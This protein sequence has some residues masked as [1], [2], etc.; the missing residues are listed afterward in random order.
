MKCSWQHSFQWNFLSS[1]HMGIYY[2]WYS[3]NQAL[4]SQGCWGR[5]GIIIV[6]FTWLCQIG[7]CNSL[8]WNRGSFFSQPGC[9]EMSTYHLSLITMGYKNL[10]W[11]L[12]TISNQISFFQHDCQLSVLRD[13]YFDWLGPQGP[14]IS[15]LFH[16]FFCSGV[17]WWWKFSLFKYI[18]NQ[19]CLDG[20]E[21]FM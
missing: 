19:E 10:L 2:Y 15:R 1:L 11:E 7:F 14:P 12:L 4:G 5:I 16:T 18:Y 13:T 21:W 6:F 17:H 20:V 8:W 9:K 3:F